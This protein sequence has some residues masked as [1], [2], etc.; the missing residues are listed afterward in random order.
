MTKLILSELGHEAAAVLTELS[1]PDAAFMDG[2]GGMSNLLVLMHRA[3]SIAGGTS[4]SNATRS[5]SGSSASRGSTRQ[6]VH[7][8]CRRV[9]LD[10]HIILT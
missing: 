3:M 8:A 1:G 6:V 2:P 9:I 10:D 5:V 7:A 4:R